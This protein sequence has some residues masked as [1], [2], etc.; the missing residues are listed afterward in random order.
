MHFID[1]EKEDWNL[2]VYL[3]SWGNWMARWIELYHL[4]QPMR[5]FRPYNISEIKTENDRFSCHCNFSTD[6]SLPYNK[7]ELC[8]VYTVLSALKNHCTP[9][10]E[11][12]DQVVHEQITLFI[13]ITKLCF[14]K[15]SQNYVQRYEKL[16]PPLK[17]M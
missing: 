4:E 8:Q 1:V 9:S 11:W 14:P 17:C 10:P 5:C 2:V 7:F 6:T 16:A 12:T 13:I 3:H 15:C